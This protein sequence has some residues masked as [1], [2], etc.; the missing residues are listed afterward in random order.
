[1]N[2]KSQFNQGLKDGAPVVF[3]YLPVGFAFGVTATAGGIP[4]WLVVLISLTNFTSAGQ[5]MGA[6]LIIAGAPIFEIAVTTLIINIRYVIMSMSFSQRIKPNMPLAE[7][8]IAAFAITDEI[9]AVASLKKG[10]V[11]FKYI[12]GLVSGP[13]A[14]WSLGTLLGAYATNLLPLA[15]QQSMGIALYAMFIALILPAA[16]ES[17]AITVVAGT[18]VAVSVLFKTLPF[19]STIS[20]GYVIIICTIVAAALGAY[21]FPREEEDLT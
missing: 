13:Y 18:A 8:M 16:R 21:F 7:K 11:T 1:M 14:F 5:L 15:V 6:T 17:L 19:L 10:D 9:F 2:T 3:G 4:P 12:T 20:A